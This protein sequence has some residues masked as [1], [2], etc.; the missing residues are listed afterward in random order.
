MDFIGIM[1]LFIP[2]IT[3]AMG[4][5]LTNIG[6]IRDRKLSIIREKFDRLYHPFLVLINELGTDNEFGFAIDSE[7]GEALKPIL[8]HLTK[9]AYLATTEGQHLIWETRYL[10]VASTTEGK[11]IDK[12]KE[13]LFAKSI[14][15]LFEHLIQEY[16]KSANA[17]GYELIGMGTITD[18]NES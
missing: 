12:D 13:E 10:F 8:E 1:Q 7:N 14:G 3:F 18:S 17:L 5:F 9:N 16:M 15:V 11:T 2:V 6:Y 4:Y